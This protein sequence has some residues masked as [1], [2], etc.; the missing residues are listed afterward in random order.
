MKTEKMHEFEIHAKACEKCSAVDF[1]KTSSL[2]N[3][4]AKG[5]PLLMDFISQKQAKIE[6]QKEKAL[7]HQFLKMDDGKVYKTTAS[8]V[9]MMTKYK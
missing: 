4:C 3:C 5:A 8:K 6:K 9:K 1:E 7:K 2:V